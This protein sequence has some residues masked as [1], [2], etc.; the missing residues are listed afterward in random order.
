LVHY[1]AANLGFLNFLAPELPGVFQDNIVHA[2]NGALWTLKIEVMFYV[3]VPIIAMLCARLG[4]LP[5][6]AATYVL[7]VVYLLFLEQIA[8]QTEREIFVFLAR[9][10]PGQLS[11]FIAGAFCY[12]YL[13]L[14]RRWWLPLATVSL[15]I[16]IAPLP[17]TLDA[18]LEPA[19]LGIF[20]TYLAV[21]V[22]YLGNF[23]RYGDLSYGV[24]IIHFPV[25]QTLIALGIFQGNPYLAV[26][27]AATLVLALAFGSWHLVEKP[28]L[29]RTSHYVVAATAAKTA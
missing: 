19:A 8:H 18:A 26:A 1:L 20:V 5:I 7:S 12:Y 13:E 27:L 15:A 4:R 22:Q 29:R 6:L 3:S 24:Y 9:Q 28:F 2:V 16:L 10:L 11:Y 21:G 14:V 17:D 25:L 23:G